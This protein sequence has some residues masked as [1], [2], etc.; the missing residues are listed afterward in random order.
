MVRVCSRAV[1]CLALD[2]SKEGVVG[3]VQTSEGSSDPMDI[4][5]ELSRTSPTPPYQHNERGTHIL[6]S[7]PQRQCPTAEQDVMQARFYLYFF[8]LSS[9][10]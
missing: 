2:G 3:K 1:A 7:R 6:Y 9:R 4:S 10:A 5:L 8:H